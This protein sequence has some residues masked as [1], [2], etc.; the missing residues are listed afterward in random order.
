[1]DQLDQATADKVFEAARTA[2]FRRNNLGLRAEVTVGSYTYLVEAGG[3]FLACID[4]RYGYGG[5]EHFYTNA[6]PEQDAALRQTI[7]D[8]GAK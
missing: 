7:A 5:D 4:G 2:T 1:M 3:S 6:T 8:Q